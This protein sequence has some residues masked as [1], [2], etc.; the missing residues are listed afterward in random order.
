MS[1]DA[2]SELLIQ[3]DSVNTDHE[4]KILDEEQNE[5][6]RIQRHLNTIQQNNSQLGKV[7]P[8]LYPN[9]NNEDDEEDDD[10]GQ[11]AQ[12]KQ[13]TPQKESAR[14]SEGEFQYQEYGFMDAFQ[15]PDGQESPGIIEQFE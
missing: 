14:E 2:N 3:Q 6:T 7:T 4:P 1:H 13:S 9:T 5:L 8:E 10:D 15:N 12:N 11:N